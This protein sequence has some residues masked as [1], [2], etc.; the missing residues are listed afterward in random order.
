MAIIT[1]TSDMGNEDYYVASVKGAILSQ[2]PDIKI[3]DITHS[4]DSFN[5]SKAAF[6]LKNTY[7]D[8][9]QGTIH[10]V[11]VDTESSIHNDHL[12]IRF[13]G[14]YFIGPNNGLFSLI[15]NRPPD[16]IYEINIKQDSDDLTFPT[17][18]IYTK[19]ACHLARGGTPELIGIKK[20]KIKGLSTFNPI[21]EN[22]RI[23]RG[24]VIY[25]D[26]YGNAITNISRG[27]FKEMGK[28]RKFVISMRNDDYN[29]TKI[30]KSYSEVDAGE[31]LALFSSSG[32]LEISINKGSAKSLFALNVSEVI[33]IEFQ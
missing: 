24:M 14:H 21:I 8:F 22:D 31:I 28:G 29:I 25:I 15:F 27:M 4:I 33:R 7:P 18:Y 13:D 30:S 11:G 23:I 5:I 10:I 2:S 6:I 16:A 32:N 12:L 17:K 26:K 3:I 20:D 9:P 19:A 1:L